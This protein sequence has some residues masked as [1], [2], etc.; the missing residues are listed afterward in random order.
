MYLLYNKLSSFALSKIYKYIV[1]YAVLTFPLFYI[2]TNAV[3]LSNKLN[4]PCCFDVSYLIE[5]S[6][7]LH[8]TTFFALT[9]LRIS[10]NE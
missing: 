2:Q 9:Y 5:V 1:V 10:L 4:Q 8:K 3:V 6:R 7:K